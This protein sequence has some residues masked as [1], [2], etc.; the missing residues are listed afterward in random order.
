M[1]TLA[2][3]LP[4]FLGLLF[5]SGC[6]SAPSR[7]NS[8]WIEQQQPPKQLLS[9]A[10][11]LGFREAGGLHFVLH[12]G[13]GKAISLTVRTSVIGA[14]LGDPLGAV[15]M[16]SSAQ[17]L[18]LGVA[19]YTRPADVAPAVWYQLNPYVF[20][21]TTFMGNRIET[22]QFVSLAP[23]SRRQSALGL[24]IGST[25]KVGS[26]RLEYQPYELDHTEGGSDRWLPLNEP[27]KAMVVTAFVEI[28]EPVAIIFPESQ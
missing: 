14:P 15:S 7:Q 4:A 25:T 1:S 20:D 18:Y 16:T 26:L 5:L 11:T 12:N 3:S 19:A 17:V 23:R 28:G 6:A 9:A 8:I 22:G 27:P 13:S 10:E 2:R 24:D 21:E